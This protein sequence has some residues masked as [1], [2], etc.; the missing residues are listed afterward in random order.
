MKEFDRLFG[1]HRNWWE[2]IQTAKEQAMA[3]QLV[4]VLKNRYTFT[5]L[6][7]GKVSINPTGNPA[8]ASGGMGDVLTGMLVAFLAQGYTPT[9]AAMLGCF[10]HGIAGDRLLSAG[11]AVVPATAVIAEIPAAIA[12]QVDSQ[13]EL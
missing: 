8:M 11:M 4:I 10:L 2:R 12:S 3:L 6:P 9:E 1:P 5:A 13:V 7:N